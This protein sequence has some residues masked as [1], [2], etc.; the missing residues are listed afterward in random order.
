VFIPVTSW[1][2]RLFVQTKCFRECNCFAKRWAAG[3]FAAMPK[4]IRWGILGTGNI[5]RQFAAGVVTS[6]RG[7]ITSVGSRKKETAREFAQLYK[8]PHELSYD[9]LMTDPN[10]DAIYNSL[11]N[12]LHHEWTIKALKSGKH[13]LCEKPLASDL[14]EAQEMFDVSEKTGKLLVEAFMYRS[15]PLTHAVVDAVNDGVIGRLKLIRTSFCYNTTRIADN[16]RFKKD[17]AGGSL[18]DIGCYC[19][20]YSRLF[21]KSEPIKIQAYAHIH[22]TGIDDIATASMEFPNGVVASFTSGMTVQADNTAY[23]CG[24][25]GFIQIPIPWKPPV[26]DAQYTIARSTPP[27]QDKLG[28]KP[29]APPWETKHVDTGKELYALEGDDFAASVFDNKPPALTK[30]DSLGNQRVLD[31]M[32]HQI[33]IMP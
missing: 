28:S 15:H 8:V 17:L 23:L 16:I 18:M 25:E 6:D 24:D 26:K 20:N 11:P 4:K 31:E 13:V 12:S 5:A 22:E 33:G 9:E 3:I 29:T 30:D 27:R 14:A 32:R 21:A 7:T 2:D 19:I 10:I 1:F